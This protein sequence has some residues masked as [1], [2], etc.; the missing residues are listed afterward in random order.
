MAILDSRVA[1]SSGST[2][3]EGTKQNLT[4]QEQ[5]C[6][7]QYHTAKCEQL[8]NLERLLTVLAFVHVTFVRQVIALAWYMKLY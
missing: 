2:A 4:V 6:K 5:T 7:V 1:Y 8:Q 3:D